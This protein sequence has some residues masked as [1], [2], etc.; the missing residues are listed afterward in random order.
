MTEPELY[1]RELQV[2][3]TAAR[4]AGEKILEFYTRQSAE[5]HEKSDG[6]LVT[7]A[8]L[9]ADRIIRETL[10]TAFPADPLLTEEGADDSQRLKSHRCWIVDPI[11][12]TNQFVER[13]GDFEVLIALV[14]GS[15]PVVSVVYQ[16]TE[17]ILISAIA[18]GGATIQTGGERRPLKFSA[19]LAT[20]PTRITTSQWLGAPANLP[21]LDRLVA[22][23]QHAELASSGIGVTVRRFVPDQQVAD[24]LVGVRVDGKS[25][26][27]WEWDFAAPDLIV[28]EAGGATTDLF[29]RLH[30]YNKP[31]PR[32]QDG[33]VMSVDHAT[34]QTVLRSL[35]QVL[36]DFGVTPTPD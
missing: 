30:Q 33:I 1:A 2:A 14:V 28:A 31:Y 36:F 34:H 19:V 7:D 35:E 9:A 11:D 27:A 24:V 12:G 6:S 32:N 15:R 23:L 29:G 25:I 16:P 8:D 18:G 10:Q 26:Y 5:I 20:V 22:S 4:K 13:T 21:L 3:E 17:N